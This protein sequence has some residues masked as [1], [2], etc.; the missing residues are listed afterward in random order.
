MNLL[1]TFI[2]KVNP[3]GE[4]T[5]FYY[6]KKY[7]QFRTKDFYESNENLIEFGKRIGYNTCNSTFFFKIR[8][9]IEKM[10][11]CRGLIPFTYLQF[12]GVKM[13][14]LD[15][16]QELDWRSFEIEKDKPRFPNQAMQRLAPAIYRT[17]HIPHGNSEDEA[18]DYLNRDDLYLLCATIIYPELLIVSLPPGEKYP[19]YEWLKPE[20][21]KTKLGLDFGKLYPRIGQTRIG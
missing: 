13:E 12:I 20:Y 21:R 17:V 3:P 2:E 4:Y 15:T 18:I 7:L 11:H 1:D 5:R 8:K 14:E 9:R 6:T 16:C 10:V 19:I